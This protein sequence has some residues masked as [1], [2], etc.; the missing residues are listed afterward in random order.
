MGL[1]SF[2]PLSFLSSESQLLTWQGQ[3]LPADTLSAQNALA[4]LHGTQ[5]P[6]IIDP[7]SQV[8]TGSD[9]HNSCCAR[10]YCLSLLQWQPACCEGSLFCG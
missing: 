9:A 3:G 2:T 1:E 10:S 8:G 5:T 6:L 7:S 4:I